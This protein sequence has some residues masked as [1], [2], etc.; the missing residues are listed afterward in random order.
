MDPSRYDNNLERTFSI[1][2]NLMDRY[3]SSL[4]SAEHL[5]L[6]IVEQNAP[7][8]RHIF[9]VLKINTRELA[10]R[11]TAN[12][13]GAQEAFPVRREQF[14]L[15][16]ETIEIFQR[17]ESFEDLTGDE[18]VGVEHILLAITMAKT[19][20]A[21]DIL[22]QAGCD[23]ESV[24]QII[25]SEIT[26]RKPSQ[27]EP[28]ALLEGSNG[29]KA[30]TER[31]LSQ[32]LIEMGE[33]LSEK[34]EAGKLDPVIGREDELS[35]VLNILSRRTKNNPVLI[36]E[37]GVGKTAIAEGL[38]LKIA[39]AEVPVSLR[40]YRVFSLDVGK[41]VAGTSLRGQFEERLKTLIEELIAL[42]GSIILFIDELHLLVGAGAT[43]NSGMD[44]GNML[45]P[46]LAR[47]QIRCIGATTFSE[48]TKYI[49]KDPA[50]A[51]RFQSVVVK[52]PT[53]DQ[54]VSI[55]RGLKDKFEVYH[56]IAIKDTALTAAAKLSHR[57]ITDRRLPDKA[58]DLVDEAASRKRLEIDSPPEDLLKITAE[59]HRLELERTSLVKDAD[60]K[61][62]NRLNALEIEIE[63]LN[64]KAAS[65]RRGWSRQIDSLSNV[66]SLKEKLEILKAEIDDAK[67]KLDFRKAAEIEH[68]KL[69]PLEKLLSQSGS[70]S[71]PPMQAPLGQITDEEIASLVSQ[72]TGIPVNRI[73]T[74]ESLSLIEMEESLSR[75]ILGQKS[76]VKAVANSV[77]IARTGLN[78]K[79]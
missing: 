38:A 62:N 51:R 61:A 77:R 50:L 16:D 60:E 70:Q 33:D 48:Y 68:D 7:T 46:Y 57:Y 2:A 78:P 58:I 10:R 15:A 79:N 17:A 21:Q 64:Q 28:G 45:K 8:T 32:A 59:I 73:S 13:Y 23:S 35:R 72:A 4:V 18:K 42:S 24:R 63:Q 47:G 54:T 76:A 56:G 39:R 30:R 1:C 44:A 41:L 20:S 27:G 40:G 55:L 22:S 37:A 26:K 71:D 11:L 34:A 74:D 69:K 9:E 43:T 6:A 19:T 66:T 12:I 36:G 49:E 14:N 31:K 5:L 25:S 29:S 67:R 75:R 65:L 52:E 3:P 53:V